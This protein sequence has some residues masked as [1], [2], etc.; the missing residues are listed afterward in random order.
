MRKPRA[1]GTLET[2]DGR[3]ALRFERWLNYPIERVWQAISVPSEL[4]CFFPGAADWIPAAGEVID[5]GEMSAEVTRVEAPYLLTWIFAGQPQ[6][7][8]LTAEGDGCR[9]VFIH[10]ID[11][12]PAAQTATGW[13]I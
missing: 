11:D 6:S 2:I 1:Y 8:E 7:F 5:V 3:S 13:E 12:L 9:L 10:V 4:E